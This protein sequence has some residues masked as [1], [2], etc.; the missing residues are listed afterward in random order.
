MLGTRLDK[1]PDRHR[2]YYSPAHRFRILE[3]KNFLGWNREVAARL[4]RI[5]PNTL[6][7]WEKHADPD[8][9]TVGSTVTPIPPSLVSLTWGGASSSPCSDAVSAARTS[10]RK[11]SLEPA[12]RSPPAPSVVS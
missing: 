7:N 10:W 2:P 5:C 3:I 12:G 11:P 9:R 4:F 1:I 6:S 8:S